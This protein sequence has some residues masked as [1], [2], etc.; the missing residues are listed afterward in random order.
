[1]IMRSLLPAL[2][3]S[4][5]LG[6]SARAGF[7]FQ[8]ADSTGA[9]STAFSIS[10]PGGTVD[11]QIWLLQ[12]GGSTNLS[13]NGLVDGG[14]ALQFSSTAPFTVSSASNITPN[15]A[16]FGGPNATSLT[17]S[18]GTTSAT[19]QVHSS[20]PVLAPTTGANANRILLGTFTFTG[21]TSGSAVTLTALP[22][23][24]SANNVDGLGNN[25]DGMIT[26][27]SAAITVV[28]EPGTLVLTSLLA[29]G[30]LAGAV[31][32]RYRRRVA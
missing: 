32:R 5:F 11:I 2:I 29:A 30:G 6:S 10:G 13:A 8:F 26:N 25:L 1:M 9:P 19:L 17:S 21:L 28:P 27:S 15:S 23:P 18:G 20:T 24:N 7:Q 3:L 31:W 12:T 16:Q 4:L 22:D 14:V